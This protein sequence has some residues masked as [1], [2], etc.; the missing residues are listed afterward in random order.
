MATGVALAI[1]FISLHAGHGRGR[2]ALALPDHLRG[3]RR[4]GHRRSSPPSTDGPCSPRSSAG[5]VIAAAD[6]RGHR[7]AHDPARQPL[8][9]AGDADVRAPHGAAGLQPEG[10]RATSAPASPSPARSSR[11]PTAASSTSALAVFAIIAILIVNLRRS[12][13]G[14]AL[15]AVRWSENASRTMGLSVIQMKMLVSG[16]A[17]FV[18]GVGGGLYAVAYKQAIPLDYATL[19]GLVWLAVLVTFGVR[20]NI[21][22]LLAGLVFAFSPAFVQTVP[23]ARARR[24]PSSRSCSSVSVPSS[25][26]RTPRARCTSRR[27][28]SSGGLHKARRRC[29]C[30]AGRDRDSP[31]ATIP[32]WPTTIQQPP[33]P[34][35]ARRHDRGDHPLMSTTETADLAAAEATDETPVD[36]GPQRDRALRR[37]GR[38]QRREPA[39]PPA[40]HRRARRAQRRGQDHALRRA[41]R[42]AP[43]AGG[44][45]V[46][47]R[48]EGHAARRRRS[49]RA[50][51]WPARSS[52]S[53]CSWASPC[54]STSCSGTGSATSAGGCGATSSPP[55]RCTR[56]PPT[57]R[58]ASTT[59][60]T[61]SAS[62][63]VADTPASV[64]PLG[65]ARR[66][67]VARALATGPSIVLLDEPSSGLDG[68]E[69]SQLGAALRTVVEEEHVSLLLVEHDVAMVLGLS[70]QVAVLDF[71]VRIAYGTPDEIRNDPAVRA[72]YLGDDEAVEGTAEPR[73]SRHERRERK[74]VRPD[75][76]APLPLACEG[77]RRPADAG[78]CRRCSTSRIDVPA[79][80]VVAVLGANGAGKSTLRPGGVGTGALVRRDG[81]RSTAATSPRRQ[82]HDIRRAGLVHI[83]EGRGIFP[84]LSV[85]ENL[86]MAVR[87]VGSADQRTVGGRPRLRDVPPPRRAPR[88]ARRHPLGWRAADA[89]AGPRAR[90]A[91]EA[92][93]RRRDV[94]RPRAARRRLRVREHRARGAD[95]ASPSCSSSSS[96]TARSASRASA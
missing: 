73:T 26:R 92:D 5:G 41:V 95:A 13:T 63:S 93:H 86:R 59:S 69:T 77:T 51:A 48:P 35:R 58:N 75:E 49:G 18:A 56:A 34:D 43:P 8:R 72:A 42:P 3:R 76:P 94:A 15:N 65:T 31:A 7:P 55:A 50:S 81:S 4:A 24:G 57:S 22:A 45:R 28:G 30:G 85:Q 39:V 68:H 14:L 2:H 37:P 62:R 70:S 78:R 36:R 66:V 9:R 52:S 46:P 89:R 33:P 88:A 25:W 10:L 60:S 67:E 21:A 11:S 54:A 6:R 84:G 90:G 12:T 80:S 91:A 87:R 64:L 96:S 19:L 44:R 74:A 71:G 47:R 27:W 83:P 40:T 16:L 17:A 82:P 29:A 23:Q 20:S 38:P 61:C 53:S 1:I 32:G 79:G